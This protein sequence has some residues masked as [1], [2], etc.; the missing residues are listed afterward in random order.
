M[1]Y[2][3]AKQLVSSCFPCWN[4]SFENLKQSTQNMQVSNL[5]S[6]FLS[7][8]MLLLPLL[9]QLH[10]CWCIIILKDDIVMYQRGGVSIKAIPSNTNTS[11]EIKPVDIV[12]LLHCYFCT[13]SLSLKW[14]K[15]YLKRWQTLKW[16]T[17]SESAVN[18][19]C[20]AVEL[21]SIQLVKL[22]HWHVTFR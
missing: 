19:L 12:N 21:S 11:R 5:W 7:L 14:V 10:A 4:W 20:S 22:M 13:V 16:A 17:L 1:V 15:P 8:P 2:L 6:Q 9:W 3:H 18:S